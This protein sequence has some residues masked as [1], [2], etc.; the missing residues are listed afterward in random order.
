[1]D[2]WQ[3]SWPILMVKTPYLHN[4]MVGVFQQRMIERGWKKVPDGTPYSQHA[5]Q[6]FLHDSD[7]GPDTAAVVWAFQKEKHL[8]VDGQVGRETWE[9]A[10][11]KDNVTP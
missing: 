4:T 1:M 6:K 3:N 2:P 5:G 11:R 10:R 9:A 8:E 7:Y